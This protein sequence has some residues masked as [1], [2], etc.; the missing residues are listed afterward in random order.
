MDYRRTIPC[1]LFLVISALLQAEEPSLFFS[2]SLSGRPAFVRGYPYGTGT[3]ARFEGGLAAGF[4]RKTAE[5]AFRAAPSLHLSWI[6]SS[7]ST[8]VSDI[9]VYRAFS[10]S[11]LSVDLDVLFPRTRVGASLSLGANYAR[12][13]DTGN[14]F[15]FPDLKAAPF[16]SIFLLS[17]GNDRLDIQLPLQISFRKDMDFDIAAGITLKWI[18]FLFSREEQ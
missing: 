11:R 2:A 7:R 4:G 18:F 1:F 16:L 6:S 12:Y 10:A 8:A 13:T 5:G 9:V 14:F 15:F 3:S 17:G